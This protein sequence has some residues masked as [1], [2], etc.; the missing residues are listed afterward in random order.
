MCKNSKTKTEQS[1]TVN[2][3]L[4]NLYKQNYA[5]A[6][7][8]ANRPFQVYTGERV[9]G[10]NPQ[11]QQAAGMYSDIAGNRI[12]GSSLD[13]AIQAAQGTAGYQPVPALAQNVT[14]GS[15]AGTDLSPYMNPFMQNVVDTTQADIE[16]QRQIAQTQMKSQA[17]GAKAWGG[18]RS[19]V[20]EAQTNDAFARTSAQTL[21]AL[22]AQ[23]FTDAQAQAQMDLN[24]R[25]QADTSNQGAN[26]TASLANQSADLNA[27]GLRRAGGTDLMNMSA[28]EL[29]QALQRAG[30]VSQSGMIEQATGQAKNDAAYEEFLRQWNYPYQQQDM[31]N[32]A[33]GMIP[34]E[35]TVKGTQTKTPGL[36]DI[37]GMGLMG[38]GAAGSLGWSP[39]GSKG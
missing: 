35:Q 18:S 10:L 31:R 15:L 32:A 19:G 4:M 20:A 22:R 36:M 34:I 33:L 37:L 13:A 29:N 14:A 25:L 24:R 30:G 3:E 21:A 11:Q 17:L 2:P 7:N 6:N 1:N 16:R 26:L 27:A 9:A 5:T 12:G 38:A 28:Q 8:L 23:G 39:F